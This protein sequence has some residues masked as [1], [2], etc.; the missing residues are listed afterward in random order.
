M[1]ILLWAK[2]SGSLKI[3]RLAVNHYII[4]RAK[5]S[6]RLPENII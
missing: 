1:M 5:K 3:M 6:F 4:R 2:L